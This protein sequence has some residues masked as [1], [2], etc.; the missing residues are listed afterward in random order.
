LWS[1]HCPKYFTNLNLA[2]FL[3][4][5]PFVWLRCYPKP[6]ELTR[7]FRVFVVPS[8]ALFCSFLLHNIDNHLRI[9]TIWTFSLPF[10]LWVPFLLSTSIISDFLLFVNNFFWRSSE[11]DYST[12]YP[13]RA[14]A[15]SLAS[16]S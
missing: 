11:V 10:T 7:V 6:F 9:H 14:Q 8:R 13:P 12:S 1:S 2:I 16:S 5:F 4:S 3:S 15:I